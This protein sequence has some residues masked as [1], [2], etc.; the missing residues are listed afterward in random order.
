[1]N[2]KRFDIWIR[3]HR[4]IKVLDRLEVALNEYL[5][6]VGEGTLADINARHM[7]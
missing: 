2:I 6:P 7:L 1:M 3:Q 5:A 4:T